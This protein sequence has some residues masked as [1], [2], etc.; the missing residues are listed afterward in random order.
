MK[1]LFLAMA[2]IMAFAT[3]SMSASVSLQWDPNTESDLA[4]YKLYYAADSTNFDNATVID[5]QNQTTT[6]VADLD[7]TK[8]YSFA[9]KAYNT[10]GMESAFSNVVTVL[11]CPTAPKN[12]K[13]TINITVSGQ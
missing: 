4:G 10:A 13:W 12:L 8:S 9:V 3:L 5:V 7:P 2:L 6:S 11:R 1:S